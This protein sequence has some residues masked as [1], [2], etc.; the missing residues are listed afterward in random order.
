[1]ALFTIF[2][3]TNEYHLDNSNLEIGVIGLAAIV[4]FNITMYLYQT[5]SMWF[6]PFQSRD[7]HSYFTQR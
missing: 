5:R 1:M 3:M 4:S 2:L 6:N 7:H